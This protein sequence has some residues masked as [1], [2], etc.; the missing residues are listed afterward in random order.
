MIFKEAPQLRDL[1]TFVPNKRYPI[2][3]WYYFKEGF[4]KELVEH[5]IKNYGIPQGSTVLDPFCGV[6]TT[7][8]TCK[9]NGINSIG[10]DVCPLFTFISKVKTQDYDLN[11]LEKN[12]NEA[13]N[14]KLEKPK[15]LPNNDF[16]KKALSRQALEDVVFYRKKISE[17]EDK[18]SRDFMMLAL[19]D[20]TTRG[21]WIVK[22]G[23][24]AR[25][26][27]EGKPPVGK[28]FRNKIKLM[29]KDLKK[30]NLGSAEV[31]IR[32]Q[33]SRNMTL[34]NDSINY[35]ITSP[36]Y[37]N[38]L[39]YTKIYKLE[40][41]LFFDYSEPSLRSY[42]GDSDIYDIGS[43][44][45]E[46]AAN[47]FNDLSKVFG[48]LYDIC[49]SHSKLFVVIGGGCF[50]NRVVEVDYHFSKLAE[51]LGFY[52]N[53][54]LVARNSWCTRARTIKVGQVRESVVILEK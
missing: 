16:L 18:K 21:S 30:S 40:L 42:I 19:I 53:D 9:Q 17:L 8:L 26:Q 36:P 43:D 28:L 24:L 23:A 38:K 32:L 27:K 12:V 48:K 35:V 11:I 13:V 4:S 5:F 52:V 3:N 49:R 31:E 20:S 50:P 51:K 45:P 37:L 6:G 46:E 47:Y 33:D 41:L 25:I 34:E 10:F 7:L 2:H 39:E 1:V 14:W 22:D 54:I 44:M 29:L 15:E